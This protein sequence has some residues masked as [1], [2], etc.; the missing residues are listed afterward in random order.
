VLAWAVRG[1]LDWQAQ[2]GLGIPDRVRVSSGEY[3][4]EMDRVG[5]FV[6][7]CCAL[8]PAHSEPLTLGFGGLYPAYAQ[9]CKEA[10]YHALGRNRFV[11]E[12]GRVVPGWDGKLRQASENAGGGRRKVSRVPGI[13][14]LED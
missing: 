3:R 12:L 10:G 2:G 9:W 4:R 11:A 5:Q 14:L 13:R 8:D 7:Q 1:C 6:E